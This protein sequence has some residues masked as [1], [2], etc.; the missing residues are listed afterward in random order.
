LSLRTSAGIAQVRQLSA[1]F[2]LTRAALYKAASAEP[3]VAKARPA[4]EP[5]PTIISNAKLLEQIQPL[6]QEHPAWGHRKVWAMLRRQGTRVSR[7]RIWAIMHQHGLTFIARARRAEPRRG[8]VAVEEPNRRWCS[9]M[10]TVWTRK[11]GWVAV[12]PV[13]DCGCRSALQI[14]ISKAQDA[15]AILAPL[16]T[17]LEDVFQDP[18]AVPEELELRTDHGSVFTGD[19]CDK[20]CTGWRVSHTFAPVGRPT[21]N[22]VAERFI[23][24]MKLELIWLRDWED[25]EEL[26]A[27]IEP[28]RRFYNDERPH[29]ALDWQTPSERRAQRLPGDR[30]LPAAA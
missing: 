27:A 22:A 11:D 30:L 10:T 18:S 4:R 14:G 3:K 26:R 2:D 21:G 25:I 29:E 28:W 1:A 19:D 5:A 24:T 15:P 6:V 20:L 8:T 13:V 12:T 9:D 7:R 16:G 17:A 23:Q